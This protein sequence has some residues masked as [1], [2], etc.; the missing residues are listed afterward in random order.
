[1][2]GLT[3]KIVKG[4]TTGSYLLCHDNSGAKEV[5]IFGVKGAGGVRSRNPSVGIGDVVIVSVKKG[6][7]DMVKKVVKALI[8]RQKKEFRR[9]NG[10]RISFEDNAAVLITDDGLPVA[11]EIKGVVAREVAERYPKVAAIAPGVV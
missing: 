11:T 3:G 5:F 1:M 8:I 10:I 9:A 6:N 4:L 7:P 2:K